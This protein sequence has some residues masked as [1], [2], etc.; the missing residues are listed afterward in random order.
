MEI[1]ILFV[2]IRLN[3]LFAMSEIALVTARK[4]RPQ[5]LV[6]EGNRS[7]TAAAEHGQD[8]THFLSAIQIGITSIGVR[9]GIVGEL[10]PK[11]I[12]QS[13]RDAFARLVARPINWLA[14]ATTLFIVLLSVFTR[15]LLRLLGVIPV[16][17]LKDRLTLGEVPDEGRGRYPHPR[18]ADDAHRAS[19]ES[20]RFGRLG[21]VA[22]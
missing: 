10:V 16:T 21:R 8:R 20:G 3:G 1:A 6:D 12:G 13:Y 4:A 22:L 15:T 19:S 5:K 17:E 9:N 2:L 18:R 11:R 7:A 14:I